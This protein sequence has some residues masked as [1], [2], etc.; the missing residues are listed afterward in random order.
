MST[1]YDNLT[2]ILSATT[3]AEQRLSAMRGFASEL[4]WTPSFEM[5]NSFGVAGADNHLVVEHGLENS[6][7]ISFLKSPRRAA[8]LDPIQLRL[9]LEISFNNLVEWPK[10]RTISALKFDPAVLPDLR[11]HMV[12]LVALDSRAVHAAE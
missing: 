11:D 6:A 5:H 9:L 7:I 1:V 2:R 4:H 12:A 10:P 3:S 8:D